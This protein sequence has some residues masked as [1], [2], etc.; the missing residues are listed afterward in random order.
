[1]RI[2]AMPVRLVAVTDGVFQGCEHV[3]VFLK[4]PAQDVRGLAFS[5]AD[6]R[7]LQA[8]LNFVLPGAQQIQ[9]ELT[10]SN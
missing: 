5:L 8:A 3:V 6:T 7:R 1:M 2:D 9:Q 10:Q 4:N